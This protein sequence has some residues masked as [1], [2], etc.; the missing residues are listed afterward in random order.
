[1]ERDDAVYRSG[2]ADYVE[3]LNVVCFVMLDC[4]YASTLYSVIVHSINWILEVALVYAVPLFGNDARY[5]VLQSAESV[6]CKG[7]FA[8]FI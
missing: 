8:R 4:D 6:R 2:I 1:M 3:R 7:G 5:A